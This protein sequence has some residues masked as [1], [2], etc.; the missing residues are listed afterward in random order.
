MELATVHAAAQDSQERRAAPGSRRPPVEAVTLGLVALHVVAVGWLVSGGNLFIDDIRAQA[1]AAGRPLWPFVVESNQTHLAPGARTV[2]WLMATYAPLEH[3][4]AVVLSLGIAALFGWSS[5]RLVRQVVANPVAR[6]LGLSWVLFAASVIPT[7]AWFRQALTTMLPLAL[8]VLATSLTIDHVREGRRLPWVLAV[9][10]HAV[11]LTF[12]ER[13]LAVPFVVLAVLLVSRESR[14]DGTAPFLRRGAITLAPHVAA[15]LVFLAAYTT[16]DYDKGEGAR[17]SLID[18]VVKIGRWVL[19]DLLPSFLGG[20]VVW[21][22]GNGPYSF[23]SSPILLVIAA[24]ALSA[25]LG[26]AAART[27]GSLRA[28]APVAIVAAAYAVPVLAMVYVGRLAQVEDITASDDLRLLPDVSAAVAIAL[29]AVVG[30]VLDRRSVPGSYAVGRRA[31]L[32]AYIGAATAISLCAVT[33]VS[34]GVRWHD[35]PVREYLANL[36]ADVASATGQ[37]VPTPVPADVVPG[38]VDP[39]F[40]TRP[41]VMLVNPLAV[42]AA[43][44]GDLSVV[45]GAGRLVPASFGRVSAATPPSGFCGYAIPAGQ[46]ELTIPL[47]ADAAYYRGSVVQVGLLAGDST[48]LNLALTGRDGTVSGPLVT[49]PP[50]LL[51]G[52]HRVYALVPTGMAVVAIIVTLGTPNTAGVCITSAQISSVAGAP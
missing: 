11:A 37:V 42:G 21:R 8:V 18:A 41:L 22:T 10:C 39:G 47:S 20:P 46:Q 4:P 15:N 16:G 27:S 25:L 38:W 17:P 49:D 19:V 40:T 50:E 28:T 44:T 1:Y 33:W 7:F 36:R 52:P 6:V 30:A 13:A 24:A 9:V 2:D 51:R 31:R 29:A 3:W 45:D 14:R 26:L 48:R 34:F 32:A 12:S 35:T 5:A 23:A 43:L